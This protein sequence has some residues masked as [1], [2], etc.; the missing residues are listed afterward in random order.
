MVTKQKAIEILH[1]FINSQNEGEIQKYI[2]QITLMNDVQWEQFLAEKSL[3]SIEEVQKMAE[4]LLA[5]SNFFPLNELISYGYNEHTLHIHV[6]PKDVK[7]L[8]SREGLKKA[9]IALIDALEK[10]QEMLKWDESFSNVN[11]VYA[12]SGLIRK[13]IS[14]VFE[15][16]DFD[17][18]S[19]P[20]EQ[21]KED[22]EL[23][24]FYEKFQDKKILGRAVLSR[25]I[26]L[27]LE[28]NKIKEERKKELL[29]LLSNRKSNLITEAVKETEK[30]TRSSVIDEQVGYLLDIEREKNIERD[31]I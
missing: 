10:I 18:K 2:D 16:L 31:T 30:V 9:E 14:K 28:W 11:Q 25:E 20:I 13:P 27:S 7:N 29:S 5:S 1:S 24:K 3:N 17:V 19:M 23:S 8:L 4:K 26:L 15:Q 22:E 6:V 21:A 12:V